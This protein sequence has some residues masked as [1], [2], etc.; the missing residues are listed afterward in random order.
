MRRWQQEVAGGGRSNVT[1]TDETRHDNKSTVT[2][3]GFGTMSENGTALSNI[4]R[5]VNVSV[6]SY[7]AC[8]RTYN[9]VVDAIHL[10]AGTMEGGKDACQSDR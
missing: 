5:A 2:V 6:F 8:A 10:C 1:T 7:E 3:V 4:L 9:D